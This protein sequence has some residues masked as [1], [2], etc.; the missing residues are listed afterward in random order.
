MW[1]RKKNHLLLILFVVNFYLRF[2]VR[3]DYSESLA[4]C[5]G[6]HFFFGVFTFDL[7][8]FSIKSVGGS[9]TF[10]GVIVASFSIGRLT[11]APTLGKF[12]FYFFFFTFTLF[13]SFSFLLLHS[14]F[15]SSPFFFPFSFLFSPS[16]LLFNPKRMACYQTPL[17]ENIS[18]RSSSWYYWECSLCFNWKFVRYGLRK[19]LLWFLIWYAFLQFFTNVSFFCRFSHFF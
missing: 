9:P 5:W 17:Q 11:G 19:V 2:R 4:V 1:T 6:N 10:F 13:L 15:F 16:L 12:F 7:I 8:N 14:L 18:S 3:S